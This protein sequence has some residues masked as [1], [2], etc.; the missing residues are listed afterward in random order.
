MPNDQIISDDR[1]NYFHINR[2]R[3]M[4]NISLETYW[5]DYVK[6]QH[7]RN[8]GKKAKF[9]SFTWQ[10]NKTKKSVHVVHSAHQWLSIVNSLKNDKR[11]WCV[12]SWQVSHDIGDDE[13]LWRLL[14]VRITSWVEGST[15]LKTTFNNLES[16]ETQ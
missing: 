7:A 9:H 8:Q 2:L 13:N 15:C 10:D 16:W 14:W 3:D 1:V 11:G 5:N 6:W 4:T 12:S